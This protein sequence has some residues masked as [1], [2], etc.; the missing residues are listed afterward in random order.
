MRNPSRLLA[1]GV[2]FSIG[3]S[4]ISMACHSDYFIEVFTKIKNEKLTKDQ[5]TSVFKLRSEFQKSKSRD[6]QRGLS[7][8]SHDKHVPTFVAACAGIL[9]DS[10]YKSAVGKDKTEVQKLR[11]EVNQ[12]KK[13]LAEIKSILRDIKK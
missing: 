4:S 1:L 10:Q 7:C 11:F 3:F 8:S 5:L 6:H 12:L 9:T 13:E 2:I